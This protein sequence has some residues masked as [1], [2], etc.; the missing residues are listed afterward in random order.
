MVKNY[1]MRNKQ[2]FYQKK[3]RLL[4]S[5]SKATSTKHNYVTLQILQPIFL[6]FD[7]M[8]YENGYT[9]QTKNF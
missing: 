7:N 6:M 2:S 9:I 3:Y 4:A 8:Q 5:I 1:Y